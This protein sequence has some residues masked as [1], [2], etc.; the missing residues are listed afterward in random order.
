MTALGPILVYAPTVTFP[1]R[2][3]V[4]WISAVGSIRCAQAGQA[5][6]INQPQHF[7]KPAC[8]KFSSSRAGPDLPSRSFRQFVTL[9]VILGG[10]AFP[11]R[12][13]SA[14]EA[15]AALAHGHAGEPYPCRAAVDKRLGRQPHR[16]RWRSC[17]ATVTHGNTRSL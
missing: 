8:G 4:G 9:P 10:L 14:V 6:S 1:I 15:D 3:T 12:P 16:H 7:T 13:V 17:S 11:D 2:T 5:T